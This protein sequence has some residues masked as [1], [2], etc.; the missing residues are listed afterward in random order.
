MIEDLKNLSNTLS[1][2][3]EVRGYDAKFLSPFAM[4]ARRSDSE[5]YKDEIGGKADD[6]TVI[7]AQ[8]KV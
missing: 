2:A 7:V 5:K 6:I 1:A 3:A 8:V 4:E